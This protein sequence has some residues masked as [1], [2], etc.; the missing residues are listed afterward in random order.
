VSDWRTELDDFLKKRETLELAERESEGA[1]LLEAE[2]FL[3]G[4]VMPA[5][6]QLCEQL[7]KHGREVK[8]SREEGLATITVLFE[9][10]PEIMYRLYAD[11]KAP[12]V[13]YAFV[14]H[15][16]GKALKAADLITD[17]E[18]PVPAGAIVQETIIRHFIR[19][20]KSVIA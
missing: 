3:D 20:Y 14:S 9:G 15:E 2:A 4:T 7:Q 16:S 11:P 17:E 6:E 13:E 18:G 8:V 12:S 5:F 10:R 1:W 19:K